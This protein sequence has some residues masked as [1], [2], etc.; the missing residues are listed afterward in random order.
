MARNV[1]I[2]YKNVNRDYQI[3]IDSDADLA[4]IMSLIKQIF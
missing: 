2:V 4:V 3:P 1:L